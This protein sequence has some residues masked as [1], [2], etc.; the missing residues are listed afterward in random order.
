MMPKFAANLSMLFTEIPFPERFEAAA[1]EGF[2]AVEYLFPYEHSK[3]ELRGLLRSAGLTQVLFNLPPG[4]WGAGDRGLASLPDRR[5]E[6]RASLDLALE[7]AE[8]LECR[9]LHVMAGNAHEDQVALETYIANIRFAAERAAELGVSILLEPL[10]GRDM[11]GYF[12]RS[13][14]QAVRTLEEIDRENVRLQLDLYH[15]QITDGDVTN[16]IRKVL[17]WISHVQIASV[18]DR[19]EPDKGELFYPHVLA[20]LD[21]AG[22]GGWVG[23]EY[24]P[25]GDTRAGLAWLQEYKEDR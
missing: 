22:Y 10:N 16:L 3:D 13:V 18:P 14:A 21:E 25:A 4:D 11:P 1:A 23:C 2:H 8:A 17:P 12:L 24:H 6:F 19:Q 5:Q 20:V 7:Y 15:A 9:Q